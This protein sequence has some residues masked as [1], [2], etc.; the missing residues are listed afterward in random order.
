MPKTNINP[1]RNN[2][3]FRYVSTKKYLKIFVPGFAFK[4]DNS[5]EKKDKFVGR[6]VQFRKLYMWLTSNS[7]SGTY[8][9]TGYRGMGKSLLVK[10]VLESITRDTHAW[11]EVVFNSGI[12][13]AFLFSFLFSLNINSYSRGVYGNYV[14]VIWTFAI[15]SALC[16]CTTIVQQFWQYLSF[17][18][19]TLKWKVKTNESWDRLSKYVM[20]YKDK[21]Q[22]SY[23]R[24]PISVNLGQ[25]ILN[26]RDVLSVI[27]YNVR[28][29]YTQFVHSRQVRPIHCSIP[30]VFVCLV[31]CFAVS[32]GILLFNGLLNDL[33]RLNCGFWS[34]L[35]N[36]IQYAF[37]INNFKYR[38]LTLLFVA[39]TG[40]FFFIRFLFKVIRKIIPFVS[41]P[42]KAIN[43]LNILCERISA[44]VNEENSAN[45]TY[46]NSVL[47]IS[48]FN[49]SRKK[50]YPI[51]NVREIEQEL[52]DIINSVNNKFMC[53]KTFQ[54]QFII[55]F[56]EMDKV[57]NAERNNKSSDDSDNVKAPEYDSSID[58]FTGT[59]GFEERKRDV[60]HLL[61][62]MKL[63]ITT[64]QAKCV[65]I[66]GHELFDASLADL[67]DREFAISSI[68][69]GVLNVDSFLSP[70]REQ[71]EV[72]SMTE[73]YLATLLL[74]EGFL[75]DRM[76]ENVDKNDVL[77]EELP[78]LR[79]YNDYLLK[80]MLITNEK[81]HREEGW[82]LI[83]EKEIQFVLE[84]LRHFAVYLA[85][86]SNGSPKKISS[87]F[88]KYIRTE[89]D[90]EQL[91][92]WGDIITIGQA[93]EKGI[94]NQCVLWFDVNTQ[95]F[96]NFVYYIASPIMKTITNEISHFGD[97]LLVTSSFILDQ[98][99]KYHG[100]G[101]SWRN[102][103]Q[104]PELLNANKNPE[105]RDSMATM[106]EFLLQTHITRISSGVNQYKFHKQISEEIT[107][108]SMSSEE[109]SAIFNFTLN[110]SMTVKRYNLHLLS[111]Y[112]K[113]SNISPDPSKYN[114]VMER[115]HENLGD[116][117][118]MDE[119]YYCAIHEYN[120]ALGYLKNASEKTDDI[121][122]YLKCCLK[123]GMSYEYRRT[124]ENAYLMYCRIVNRL[125]HLRWIDEDVLGLDYTWKRTKDWRNKQPLLINRDTLQDDKLYIKNVEQRSWD[126]KVER[127]RKPNDEDVELEKTYNRQIKKGIWEDDIQ[128]NNTK[129][130]EYSTGTDNI[131]SALA[132]N[133]TPEKSDIVKRLTMFEDIRYVYLAIIA[134][135]FVI[136]KMEQGGVS[137]SSIEIA[138]AEFLYLHSTTNMEGKFM[139]SADFFHKMSEIMYYK[140]GY[141]TPLPN[142]N[143]LVSTLYFYDFN[144]LGFIDDFCYAHKQFDAV[145]AKQQIG[146]FF[147]N[148]QFDMC[149]ANLDVSIKDRL[150]DI[151]K[152]KDSGTIIEYLNY[153]PENI[154]ESIESKKNKVAH[155]AKRRDLFLKIGYKLPC[156]ACR[157]AYRS[158]DI[159]MDYLF[160][161]E[162]SEVKE[163][164][165][166][167]S[168]V[169]RLLYLTSR[170]HIR[171]IRQSEVSI[172]ADTA[173]QMADVMLSCAS[174]R[175]VE[176]DMMSREQHPFLHDYNWDMDRH[177]Q[178]DITT[179]AIE[180][181]EFLSGFAK[182]ETERKEKIDEL[183]KSYLSKLD[184]S[185]LYYW[186]ASRFYEIASL[187]KEA[188]Y[189]IERILMV[190]L[191]YMKVIGS[192]N[193]ST[194][195]SLNSVERLWGVDKSFMLVDNLFKQ[196]AKYVGMEFENH[197]LGEVHEHKWLFHFERM[198]DI[199]LTILSEFSDLKSTFL[200]AV[201]IKIRALNYLKRFQLSS[202]QKESS[203]DA[204]MLYIANI[205]NRISF[206]YR[207]DN[208]FKEEV[209][210]YFM[211][212]YIN[213]LIMVDLLGTDIMLYEKRRC[214]D[215]VVGLKKMDYYTLFYK[216]LADFLEQ[217][218]NSGS[219][220]NLLFK[221]DNTA[222]RLDLIE[223]LIHDSI[224]CISSIL[225][226]L[227]PHN[228]I[229]TFSNVFMAEIYELLWEW[230]KYYELVYDLYTYRKYDNFFD[231]DS[232]YAIINMLSRNTTDDKKSLRKAMQDCVKL[233][234]KEF[235]DKKKDVYPYSRLLMN[236]RHDIDDATIHHLFSNVAADM[237]IKYYKMAK[238]V[239]N[240][241]ASYKNMITVMY[242][243][244]DDLHNDTCQ[245]NLADE[246]YLW[247]C[248][249]I[250]R[251]RDML[252]RLYENSNVNQ[253]SSFEN[254]IGNKNNHEK[255]VQNRLDD[256]LYVNSEY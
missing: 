187:Y 104:M 26:E 201:E 14:W 123:I 221:T 226:I 31:S 170:K 242:V 186:A 56:D 93:K 185:I 97:K 139:I 183:S 145:N 109:A 199:D 165:N 212:A 142:V 155:C 21:R 200:T 44:N 32:F 233:I 182:S 74:P 243:L 234:Q 29:K 188:A 24:I 147:N 126:G 98:I 157:Y 206:P 73:L 250:D 58:G 216:A 214:S 125:I 132:Y 128:A 5:F 91:H 193:S 158:L 6:E 1:I 59:L 27:A 254:E 180:L 45:S 9:I 121:L 61:A 144:I 39:S 42:Y 77:K 51:A 48:L 249:Y 65:F 3:F 246:R 130:N 16:L 43:R 75:L 143:R 205:Y 196:A 49:K 95:R 210:G 207:H 153:I 17:Y 30:L 47:T 62:N 117:Y 235:L 87:Y 217:K 63:F 136:E 8:L 25:E 176:F 127:Y 220:H 60:L 230:S 36:T 110:E 11:P 99:Y 181:L 224:V 79:W 160:V 195:A 231:S 50:N 227:T 108:M 102:L 38:Y 213:K 168:K 115:L 190:L 116:I 166:K 54:A 52:Q 92:E 46:S 2:D 237:S 33:T 162:N 189:C 192:S 103:E 23:H 4:H 152:S 171:H 211:K 241:G 90:V 18:I 137:Y 194:D 68:F 146:N 7:K 122:A 40:M 138:E 10:R 179:A 124:Y 203:Q 131:I 229:T 41:T 94:T 112:L 232:L 28:N 134:K 148:L 118:Y 239:N 22:Q 238:D 175:T 178:D 83:R 244:D 129:N 81:E 223:F 69:N 184:K 86:I 228:H 167:I 34:K 71:N 161:D 149:F 253:L 248:G 89:Y 245:A 209:M 35:L 140:N 163:K 247:H 256:S 222:S 13:F 113:L 55:V 159:L 53:P 169:F 133:Y 12:L 150:K 172:L 82:I 96:I 105:L 197:V 154:W 15:L 100:K 225:A 215:M 88:E 70:E 57:S 240:E 141:V 72:S 204:Y 66:S 84:F 156:N 151:A 107:F 174:T 20:K 101:F 85:H 37:N 208:T 218:G 135:L 76:M 80:D 119:D 120:N 177:L 164:K 219:M 252:Y 67:S 173:M 19:R 202:I 236:I 114:Q 198:D 191:G 111:Y 64:V 78:S 255:Q 106:M 251:N